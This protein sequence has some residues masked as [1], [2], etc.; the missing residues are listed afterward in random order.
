M[1]APGGGRNRA[2]DLAREDGRP[3]APLAGMFPPTLK[4]TCVNS[5][6]M[7]SPPAATRL[8]S[9]PRVRSTLKQ[10]LVV[11]A[12]KY[13]KLDPE[14]S[15]AVNSAYHQAEIAIEVHPSLP[16][17]EA[18]AVALYTIEE[19]PR[20]DSVYF[21]VNAAL[22]A[23]DRAGCRPWRDYIWLLM[24]GL[25]KL[26]PV[27]PRLTL[28]RGCNKTP[29]EMKLCNAAGT[30]SPRCAR[31]MPATPADAPLPSS[32]DADGRIYT[33]ARASIMAMWLWLWIAL[34]WLTRGVRVPAPAVMWPTFSSTAKTI[35]VMQSFI[36]GEGS[37]TLL[38]L[39]MTEYAPRGGG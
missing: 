19:E 21:L 25:Q 27:D 17:E 30:W 22:R 38:M 5:H 18:A 9:P 7:P 20:E 34:A 37:R 33:C 15:A 23:Q 39:T 11:L 26:P 4:V 8:T 24:H 12:Q 32:L 14:E 29:E 3:R 35:D 28:Y 1:A 16:L 13:P 6:S 10:S 36:G 2:L 31:H